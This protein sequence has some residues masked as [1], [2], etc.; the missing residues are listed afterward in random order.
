MD[1][2]TRLTSKAFF[3]LWEVK[4]V[5]KNVDIMAKMY[6]VTYQAAFGTRRRIKRLCSFT[7]GEGEDSS[8]EDLNYSSSSSSSSSGGDRLVAF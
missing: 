3:L 5:T 8:E 4:E 1:F 6:R 2:N 7:F